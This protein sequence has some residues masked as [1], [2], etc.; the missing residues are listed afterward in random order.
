[1]WGKNEQFT[2]STSYEPLKKTSMEQGG[3]GG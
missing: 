2:L 1:M 3:G